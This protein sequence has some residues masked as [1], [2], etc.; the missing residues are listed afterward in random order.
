MRR[1]RLKRAWYGWRKVS[2]AGYVSAGPLAGMAELGQ[3]AARGQGGKPESFKGFSAGPGRA[4]PAPPGLFRRPGCLSRAQAVGV[5][6]HRVPLLLCPAIP[7]CVPR[8]QGSR[9]TSRP[10]SPRRGGPRRTRALGDPAVSVRWPFAAGWARLHGLGF[11]SR[12]GERLCRDFV[13]TCFSSPLCFTSVAISVTCCHLPFLPFSSSPCLLCIS[14]H[15]V[16]GAYLWVSISVP[17]LL[18]SLDPVFR[19]QAIF[20]FLACQS[21]PL[22]V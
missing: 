12:P 5:L 6:V 8:H 7:A 4:P 13:D 9:G 2:R 20:S 19:S 17:T 22:A 11:E 1:R 3:R 18:L 14:F 10:R 16:S 15:F 21:S